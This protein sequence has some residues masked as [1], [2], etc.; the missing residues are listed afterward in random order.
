MD[1]D[2]RASCPF[3]NFKV[4]N[5][6]AQIDFEKIT[7]VGSSRLELGAKLGRLRTYVFQ[8]LSYGFRGFP[9]PKIVSPS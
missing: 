6:D 1:A 8:L 5:Q 7:G 3:E 2:D 9:F 4:R